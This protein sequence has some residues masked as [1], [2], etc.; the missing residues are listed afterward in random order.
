MFNQPTTLFSRPASPFG[1]IDVTAVLMSDFNGDPAVTVF[2]SG[3]PVLVV[4]PGITGEPYSIIEP[5][6]SAHR[7]AF[8]GF[9][10]EIGELSEE[11]EQRFVGSIGTGLELDTF[12]EVMDYAE[13]HPIC[14]VVD[15]VV[16]TLKARKATA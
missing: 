7:Q 10:H 9:M 3:F 2:S 4:A 1:F 14:G 6:N 15:E 8:I 11:L 5:A 16:K 13:G 12:H